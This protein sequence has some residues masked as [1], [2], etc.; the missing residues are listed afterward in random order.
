MTDAPPDP[1]EDAARTPLPGRIPVPWRRRL[2]SVAKGPGQLVVWLGLGLA[3]LWIVGA[4]VPPAGA[5]GIVRG[6]E[7]ALSFARS[8]RISELLVALESGVSAGTPIARLDDALLQARIVVAQQQVASVAADVEAAAT[9][10]RQLASERA[11][12]ALG[13]TGESA[14][15][16]IANR[17]RVRDEVWRLEIEEREQR[18]SVLALEVEIETDL[19]RVDQVRA[20]EERFA[21]LSE[22]GFARE[23]DA[24]DRRLAEKTL[25]GRVEAN[26]RLLEALHNEVDAAAASL[27]TARGILEGLGSPEASEAARVLLESAAQ[28]ADLAALDALHRRVESRRA[29]VELLRVELAELTL[30]APFDGRVARVDARAGQSVVAGAAVVLVQARG[31]RDVVVYLPEPIAPGGTLPEMV[32]LARRTA[33]GV[34]AEAEVVGFG[35]GIDP[36]PERLWSRPGVPEF[37]RTL[38]VRPPAALGLVPG[39]AVNVRLV[40]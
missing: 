38:I 19:L 13:G 21:V 14:T 22:Q 12:A 37:G 17:S 8:G 10:R 11:L 40:Y 36:L 15:D 16:L 2:E 31:A 1:H 24:Q 29:E 3:G 28:V 39:E 30:I 20:Q 35:R 5:V 18:L 7:L 27:A 4:P 33:P 25:L 34:D 23:A 32:I 9:A 26:R 6:D